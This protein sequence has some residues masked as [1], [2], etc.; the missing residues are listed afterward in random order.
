MRIFLISLLFLIAGCT[1][2]PKKQGYLPSNNSPQFNGNPY[3]SD[4]SKDYVYKAQ[5]AAFNKNFSGI[6]AIKKLGEAHHR[7][8]FTTELGNSIF[9]F[10][11]KND[12]FYVNKIINELDRKIVINILKRDFFTLL[13]ENPKIEE[14]YQKESNLIQKGTILGKNHYYLSKNGKLSKIIRTKNESENVTIQFHKVSVKFAEEIF[15]GHKKINLSI[16]LKAI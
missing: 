3:F 13:F 7:L 5:I 8:V 2:Y 4:A 12:D 6:L 9:D 16:K 11:F 15:I 1:S 10:T 14:T